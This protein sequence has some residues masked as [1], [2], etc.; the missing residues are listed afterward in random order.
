[1]KSFKGGAAYYVPKEKM[2][3][4]TTYLNDVLEAKEQGKSFLLR[5][6]DRFATYY[7]NKFG[8][9]WKKVDK[10]LWNKEFW[11]RLHYWE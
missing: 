2:S 10:D 7:D 5:W 9:D 6:L 4:I 8:P 3:E 1:V 11:N